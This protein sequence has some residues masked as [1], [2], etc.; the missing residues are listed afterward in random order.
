MR[1]RWWL[2]RLPVLRSSLILQRG[3]GTVFGSRFWPRPWSVGYHSSSS[4]LAWVGTR[5]SNSLL[6]P[7]GWV[8]SPLQRS[9]R[10]FS[11]VLAVIGSS[12]FSGLRSSRSVVGRAVSS[13]G[14]GE[15]AAL[16]QH[17]E[18]KRGERLALMS[19]PRIR[20]LP[21]IQLHQF[22]AQRPPLR[23]IVEPHHV[24]RSGVGRTPE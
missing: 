15:I 18:D 8:R 9:P 1:E 7:A 4:S 10:S 14:L 12:T 19:P 6:P 2:Q 17:R 22:T 11:D 20:R 13:T 23:R 24:P 5:P 21:Q 3:A 16:S